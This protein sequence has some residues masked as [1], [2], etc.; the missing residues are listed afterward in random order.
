MVA[1]STDMVQH[2]AQ[3]RCSCVLVV[4]R[5][6]GVRG[7]NE[8]IDELDEDD[9]LVEVKFSFPEK[10]FDPVQIKVDI[11]EEAVKA[12]EGESESIEI[13]VTLA[14]PES[15]DNAPKLVITDVQGSKAWGGGVVATIKRLFKRD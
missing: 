9:R 6:R 13:P 4:D 11:P 8:D 10:L 14:P 1:R 15:P 2:G 12:F 3:L 7:L 5:R